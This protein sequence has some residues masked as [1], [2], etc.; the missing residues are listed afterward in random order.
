MLKAKKPEDTQASLEK[1]GNVS[2]MKKS[3]LNHR[4]AQ[5][6]L[7]DAGSG[8]HFSRR[9]VIPPIQNQDFESIQKKARFDEVAPAAE[10]IKKQALAPIK[11]GNVQRPQVP[12]TAIF[13]SPFEF[14]EYLEEYPAVKEFA[15]GVPKNRGAN[16][17]SFNPYDLKLVEYADVDKRSGY[18]TISRNVFDQL[19]LIQ[20]RALLISITRDMAISPR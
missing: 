17:E 3:T 8:E 7:S 14:I 6:R 5:K 4:P 13:Q 20:F 16:N 10:M 18:F 1:S 9:S 11:P 2:I 15:Y 19:I 12:G